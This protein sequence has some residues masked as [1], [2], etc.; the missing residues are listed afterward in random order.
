MTTGREAKAEI[1]GTTG[2]SQE[3]KGETLDDVLPARSGP[4]AEGP[5]RCPGSKGLNINS[6]S[7][8]RYIYKRSRD[9]SPQQILIKINKGELT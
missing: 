9:G 6:S 7:G 2:I 8:G 1:R 3:H 5:A 4:E